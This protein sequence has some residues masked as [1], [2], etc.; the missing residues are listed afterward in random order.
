MVQNRAWPGDQETLRKTGHFLIFPGVVR[1]SSR[2]EPSLRQSKPFVCP[3]L[4]SAR[5][6]MSAMGED[7]LDDPP[8]PDAHEYTAFEKWD[9]K[10]V[11]YNGDQDHSWRDMANSYFF[12]C[13]PLIRK[14]A[15]GELREDI[16]GTAAVFLFRH[17]LELE[18]KQIVFSGRLL[19]VEDDNMFN[20]FKGE[21]KEVARIHTLATLWDWVL[22]EA[23]PK[24]EHW[25]DYDT[26]SVEKCIREFDAVDPKGFAFRYRGEGGE[27]CRYD[28]GAL[29]SQMDHIRQVLD[30]IHT[31]LYEAR[32]QI[33]EYEDYLDSEFG[34]EYY[35]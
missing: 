12:A 24:V 8:A 33:R 29:W 2:N 10:Q 18:L 25:D 27:Y 22:K 6:T 5:Y 16:E 9:Y 34:H 30:G 23:K 3:Q 4:S 35:D 11:I 32:Q 19:I 14:L 28:F 20:A 26:E 1:S 17:Y 13:E 7:E 31:C 15:V 21:V